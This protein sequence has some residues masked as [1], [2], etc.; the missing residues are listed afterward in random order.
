MAE[1]LI[2]SVSALLLLAGLAIYS[3]LRLAKK[4][5]EI[6]SCVTDSEDDPGKPLVVRFPDSVFAK[7]EQ[8]HVATRKG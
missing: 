5:D 1:I 2:A 3:A 8:A 6:V 7:S 4:T